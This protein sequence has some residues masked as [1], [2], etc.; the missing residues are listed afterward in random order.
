MS[1]LALLSP[2]LQ[3][4]ADH[5]FLLN[6]LPVLCDL[7]TLPWKNL[8]PHQ[9]HETC[10]VAL[11]YDYPAQSCLTFLPIFLYAD[12]QHAYVEASSLV[13]INVL[14]HIS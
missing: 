2:T 7:L 13:K 12:A 8:W 6:A 14:S 11:E 9:T 4:Y 3:I 1:V 10:C 5:P